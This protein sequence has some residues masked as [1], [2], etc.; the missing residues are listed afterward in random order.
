M[1]YKKLKT[2]FFSHF[3]IFTA[4]GLCIAAFLVAVL[5]V[6]LTSSGG[7]FLP[8]LAEVK[9]TVP[10]GFAEHPVNEI[11]VRPD[12]KDYLLRP[13][14]TL[15]PGIRYEVRKS[16]QQAFKDFYDQMSQGHWA[17]MAGTGSS[18]D[19]T[20]IK[21]GNGTQIVFVKF[22]G[23]RQSEDPITVITVIPVMENK[24]AF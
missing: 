15:Q 20:V 8:G 11:V 17:L 3:G 14:E 4:S 7:I 5:I 21:M 2:Y 16:Y 10:Q 22:E 19:T 6:L 1:L 12:A 24:E 18:G 23:G 13:Q 9:K